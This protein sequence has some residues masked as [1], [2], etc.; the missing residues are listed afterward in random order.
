MASQHSHAILGML[1][2]VALLG[3]LALV[4]RYDLWN[5]PAAA[6]RLKEL[7]SHLSEF[8]LVIGNLESPLTTR[9]NTFIPKSM[10]LYSHPESARLL[11]I[12]N[13]GAVNLA[14]NHI[15]DFGRAGID[16][17]ITALSE[18]GVDWFGIDG[19]SLQVALGG[20]RLALS[21]FACLSTNGTGYG[22]HGGRGVNLLTREALERQLNE[23]RAA[24]A[25]SVLSLHWGQ[26][27]TH[28][29]NPEHL[30][31]ARSLARSERFLVHGHHPHV[32]QGVEA[33]GESLISYSLG[34]CLFD[35]CD[36]LDGRKHL[37]QLPHNRRSIVIEVEL[38]GGRIQNHHYTGFEDTDHGIIL[39]EAPVQEVM[40]YSES[41]SLIDDPVA[42]RR[43]R[44][45][46]IS[47]T[48]AEKFG[49]R[50]MAWLQSRLN[51]HSVGARITA[52]PGQ[53]LYRR[54]QRGF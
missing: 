9:R 30:R 19:R 12:L 47:A 46:E 41:L 42:Y 52:V 28:L 8:D 50:D 26:E 45:D 11:S 5:S 29:P 53:L 48:R 38:V 20:E 22:C 40:E 14:N 49:A 54:L 3:D 51:Y 34:N 13:V 10:H 1:M 16:Q 7:G 31:L 27:H 17:T 6:G 39:S 35:D 24:G 33:V 23:D 37:R 44:Q 36:S 18:V 2:R 43:I 25:F 32:L 15:H 4:G 21:G